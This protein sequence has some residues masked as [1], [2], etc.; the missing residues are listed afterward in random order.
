MTAPRPGGA[1]ALWPQAG[2]WDGACD[3]L[4]H[5]AE[6]LELEEGRTHGT[7][8][9]GR[10]FAPGAPFD[11]A[12]PFWNARTGPGTRVVVRARPLRKDTPMG[13]VTVATWSRDER[14]RRDEPTGEM[15]LDQD[16]L[17]LAPA[18]DAIELEVRLERDDPGQASP[19]LTRLGVTVFG[20]G[21]GGPAAPEAGSPASVA[22]ARA[23]PYRSQR[24]EDPE[25]AMRIC[26]P[27]S[28]SMALEHFEV[29]RKTF[30]VAMAARDPAGAIAFGNWAYLCATAAEAGLAAEV[31]AL[32]GLGE[33]ARVLEAGALAILSISFKEGELPEAPTAST[34]GHLVLATGFDAQGRLLVNDPVGHDASDGRV[35]YDP[36]RF[37]KA[38]KRGIAIVLTRP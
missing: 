4:T 32:S 20:A 25:I 27:T 18:A 23:I 6:A 34:A 26:G 28:L 8:R 22:A 2:A 16:T 21:F 1:T 5:H 11:R 12:V 10:P 9:V 36:V 24:V 14:G 29:R 33:L 31:R 15:S 38:W 17:S 7:F 19:R 3:G 13:W 37:T 35:A 30:D